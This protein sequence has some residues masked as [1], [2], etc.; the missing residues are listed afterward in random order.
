MSTLAEQV[1]DEQTEYEEEEAESEGEGEA[2]DD[3]PETEPAEEPEA[4]VRIGPEEIR[5]AEQTRDRYRKRIAELFGKEAVAHECLLCAGLGYLPELPPIGTS[6]TLA[7]GEEGI[8]LT[9]QE[10]RVEPPYE[11]A[12]DKE[13]CPMCEGYG[14]TLTGAKTDGGRL[15][16]C[17]RCGGAGWVNTSD[18]AD[19]AIGFAGF[20]NSTNALA[21]V[22]STPLGNDAW[23]REPGHKHWGVPPNMIP[24]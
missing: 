14:M 12:P 3:E 10:P 23:G 20:P 16:Q 19:T 9:F 7:A 21:P 1:E 2:S 6:F 4:G 13:T 11:Q 8:E 24:G 22:P 5:K 18:A 15:W 17:G